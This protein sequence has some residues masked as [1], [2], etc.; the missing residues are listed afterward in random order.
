[1]PTLNLQNILIFFISAALQVLSL[2]VLPLTHGFSRAV[3]AIV[4][5][6][7]YIVALGLLARLIQ[8]GVNLSILL[9]FLGAAV[10]L[11]IIAVGVVI[12]GD[13]ASPAKLAVLIFASGLIGF[14][15]TL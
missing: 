2:S 9:P 3:P 14:A 1:M 4:V 7:S 13:S 12:Y 11:I 8:A 5:S 15:S 6:V 10:P